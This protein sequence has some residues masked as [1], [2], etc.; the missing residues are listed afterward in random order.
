VGWLL[1]Y[2]CKYRHYY[3]SD[4]WE[5]IWCELPMKEGYCYISGGMQNDSWLQFSGVSISDGGYIR[6]EL[7]KILA[8]QKAAN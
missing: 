2:V 6:Q 1:D 5:F 7:D 4:S 8:K 3:P